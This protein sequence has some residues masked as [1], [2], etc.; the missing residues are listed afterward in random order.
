MRKIIVNFFREYNI[1]IVLFL[2]IVAATIFVPN[3]TKPRNLSNLI[4]SIGTYGIMVLGLTL[5]FIVGAIDLSVGFQAATVA[6]TVVLISNKAGF[7]AG[8]VSGLLAGLLLGYFNGS[9]VTKLKITPLIATLATMTA[10]EGVTLILTN[11]SSVSLH[12]DMMNSLYSLRIA[13]I[14][15]PVIVFTV[16][17]LAFAF[18]LRYTQTGINFY[19]TGGNKEAGKL[20][21]I[22]TDKLIRLA[23]TL[24]GL[25]C[26]IV[27]IL[28]A[29]RYNSAT[30]N[31]AEN[32]DVTAISSCVIGGV[33]L[34]GG[35]GNMVQALLGVMVI[36]L[37][38]N[39]LTLL[40][41]YGAIQTLIS[42]LVVVAVLLTDKFT[43]FDKAGSPAAPA[44]R[45]HPVVPVA[46]AA[47][48]QRAAPKPPKTANNL[49]LL[50]PLS[51]R[52]WPRGRSRLPMNSRHSVTPMAGKRLSMT[53][54]AI[55]Q[56]RPVRL[57]QS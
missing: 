22:N 46:P 10:M 57:T 35:K 41:V 49:Q 24:A 7:I 11:N 54:R 30:Y 9:V 38:N 13:G 15:L 37:I 28:L 44:A 39:M 43:Q 23:Y 1:V 19:I 34:M 36:Q 42:G 53:A 6:V 50:M 4:V 32:L 14:R 51:Q 40:S 18:F 17:L 55:W 25:S 27:G 56:R 48:M 12:N 3:F 31:L 26:G 47:P 20:S 52:A 5:V 2:L 29:S 8:A 33:K 16:I 21:G 45:L